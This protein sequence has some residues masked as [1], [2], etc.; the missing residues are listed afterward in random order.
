[1]AASAEPS[2]DQALVFLMLKQAPGALGCRESAN[3]SG[4]APSHWADEAAT[5][6]D[7]SVEPFLM[8]KTARVIIVEVF[9]DPDSRLLSNSLVHLDD[10]A[11]GAPA[12]AALNARGECHPLRG[13]RL[14]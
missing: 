5:S 7:R 4:A 12:A 10:V 11:R 8:R 1:M 2:V 14:P 6:V 3:A 13:R 9:R